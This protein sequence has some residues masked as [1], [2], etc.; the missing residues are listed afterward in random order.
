MRKALSI[1]LILLAATIAV[2]VAQADPTLGERI[3][4]QEQATGPAEPLGARSEA[5]NQKYGLGTA[6]NAAAEAALEARSEA[7]NQKYGLGTAGNA[8]AEA[9]LEARSEALNQKYGLG[10]AGEAA[11][12]PQAV[13]PT[14]VRQVIAQ[15][16]ARAGDPAIFGPPPVQVVGAGDGFDLRDAGIGGATALVLALLASAALA[17]RSN[18]RH[19]VST[20]S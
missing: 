18:R 3:I 13:Q 20:G 10:T 8:A 5:L 16:R 11:A 7:L 14:A 19:S 15:E 9:A 4:A 1:A 17:L 12:A 2:P 6:G